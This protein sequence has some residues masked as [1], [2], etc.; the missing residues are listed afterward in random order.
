[1]FPLS[2][3]HLPTV[4]HEAAAGTFLVKRGRGNR[5]FDPLPQGL[6][7]QILVSRGLGRTPIWDYASAVFP[8]EGDPGD[9]LKKTALGRV[10]AKET[11]VLSP[12]FNITADNIDDWTAH[13]LTY[14]HSFI[15]GGAESQLLIQTAS[16][17][18]WQTDL[19]F[20][21]TILKSIQFGSVN[22]PMVL[23]PSGTGGVQVG[24]GGNARGQYAVDLQAVRAIDSQVASG[25][26]SALLGGLNN[27][28]SG[29]SSLCVAGVQN[30][31]STLNSAIIGGSGHVIGESS[32]G[33]SAIVGGVTSTITQCAYS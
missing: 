11:F 22:G 26:Y 4:S 1:M 21:G 28:V 7:G 31:V 6:S 23:V 17:P 24:T 19:T 30:S 10:W 18:T 12:A 5:L 20:D 14:N 32:L 25:N 8:T 13:P 3:P 15:N 29:N 33:R 16:G 2:A 27:T 9:V